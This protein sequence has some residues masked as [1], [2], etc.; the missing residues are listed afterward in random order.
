[1]VLARYASA[2]LPH[3]PED[4]GPEILWVQVPSHRAMMG[5]KI[6]MKTHTIRRSFS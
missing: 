5:G 4:L 3:G 6:G 2:T 1:M